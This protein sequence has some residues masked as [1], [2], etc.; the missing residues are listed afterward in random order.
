MLHDQSPF[1]LGVGYRL[2]FKYYI[3][4]YIN[5]LIHIIFAQLQISRILFSRI[6]FSRTLISRTFIFRAPLQG[7]IENQGF[8]HDLMVSFIDIMLQERIVK[9]TNGKVTVINDDLMFFLLLLLKKS[10]I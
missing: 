3:V 6:Q 10:F 9:T 8:I 2:N 1:F 5:T 4:C 7:Y